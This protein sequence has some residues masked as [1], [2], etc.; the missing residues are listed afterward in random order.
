MCLGLGRNVT[1]FKVPSYALS[2]GSIRIQK[3]RGAAALP[4]YGK[5]T[6]SLEAT[7]MAEVQ[8][9]LDSCY[10]LPRQSL[11]LCPT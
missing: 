3:R 2:H 8:T 4:A 9:G 1:V 7:R 11:S 5:E 10:A 6:Q